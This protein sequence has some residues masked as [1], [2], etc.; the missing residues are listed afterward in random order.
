MIVDW[1]YGAPTWVMAT[2]AVGLIVCLS[3]VGLVITSRLLPP[4]LRRKHNEFVG[5]NSALIGVFFA[6]LLA[7]IA[8]A[9][10]ESFGKAADTAETEAT[11]T[12]DLWRDAFFMPEPV[13]GELIGDV[14][15]YVE[16]V[17][18]KEWPAMAKGEPVGDDGWTP[19][20]RLH[21]ALT[22]VHTTDPLQVMMVGETINRLNSLYDARRERLLAAGGHLEPTV[23]GVVLLGTFI[24]IVFTYLFGMESFALHML[25]TGLLAATLALVIVLIIAFDY[26][27]RGRVQVAPDGFLDVQHNMEAAGIGFDRP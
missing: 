12:G 27:F 25:M 19:L 1:I 5:F 3:L 8:V 7:F 18:T 23:W 2:A 4:D 22:G 17:L 10:W 14:R 6:V 20:F 21:E 26:P 13:R 15:D 16:I 9:V 24:T 11:L